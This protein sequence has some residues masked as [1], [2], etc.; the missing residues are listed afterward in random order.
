MSIPESDQPTPKRRGFPAFIVLVVVALAAVMFVWFQTLVIQQESSSSGNGE[1]S[2]VRCSNAGPSRWNPPTVSRGQEISS[3]ANMIPFSLQ[4]MKNDL[5]SLRAG[6]ACE[7]ARD[8]HTNT[9]I[10]TT[11]AAGTAILIGYAALN[12]RRQ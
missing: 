2:T 5:E 7:Q 9:L 1:Y 11:F 10:V 8:A 12:R 3:E 4:V 6:L